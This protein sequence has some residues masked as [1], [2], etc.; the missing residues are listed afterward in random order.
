ML[1]RRARAQEQRKMSHRD[2]SP[3]RNELIAGVLQLY[4]QEK[5][6][7]HQDAEASKGRKHHNVGVFKR[8]ETSHETFQENPQ[9]VG[10]K[11]TTFTV[12][13]ASCPSSRR[14][15][16]KNSI[17]AGTMTTATT[18]AKYMKNTNGEK[19]EYAKTK[20]V[21]T[22]SYPAA[23]DGQKPAKANK[24]RRLSSSD[25][26]VGHW[27]A[28]NNDAAH[29]NPAL[30]RNAGDVLLQSH[31]PVYEW[32]GQPVA[33]FQENQYSDPTTTMTVVRGQV[34]PPSTFDNVSGTSVMILP[35]LPG[36]VD[37][38][39]PR[40]MCVHP[41]VRGNGEK[42]AKRAKSPMKHHQDDERS[43]STSTTASLASITTNAV[44]SCAPKPKLPRINK[45]LTLAQL[46][47]EAQ[48]RG[49]DVKYL[50]K[51][52]AELYHHLGDCSIHLS[53][54]DIWKQVEQIRNQI[55]QEATG[56]QH[57]HQNHLASG[58]TRKTHEDQTIARGKD[59][60]A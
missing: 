1:P 29:G 21:P 49:M 12:P 20:R 43:L 45:K 57:F 10:A 53:A 17:R 35:F 11:T 48:C 3:N 41:T 28:V 5:E 58:T 31:I 36:P 37:V 15:L 47:Y 50:P 16:L 22:D 60:K 52:K 30:D 27:M 44:A 56:G 54:T 23:T 4:N 59:H 51:L 39:P 2:L 8:V 55:T 34:P 33:H 42:S 46:K 18:A 24:K 13:M 6:L 7:E 32:R 14:C 19:V 40:L 25:P 9:P 38:A 26:D